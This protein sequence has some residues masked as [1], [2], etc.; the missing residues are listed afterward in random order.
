[1]AVAG[2]IVI[3][4]QSHETEPA[5]L[6]CPDGIAGREGHCGFELVL[7][8]GGKIP[9]SGRA[10]A[11][12]HSRGIWKA[13]DRALLRGNVRGYLTVC[14]ATEGPL[15][16]LT[17]LQREICQREGSHLSRWRSD[18]GLSM[19]GIEGE[20]HSHKLHARGAAVDPV[21]LICG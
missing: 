7:S 2:R 3:R 16:C 14:R 19:D 8:H 4:V 18:R 17:Q 5:K 10:P 20:V 21:Q 12:R 13:S 11:L 6:D 9:G 15:G 1:M